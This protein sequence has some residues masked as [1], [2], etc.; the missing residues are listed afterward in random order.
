[1]ITK[2]FLGRALKDGAGTN[3][4]R[5]KRRLPWEVKKLKAG[6]GWGRGPYWDLRRENKLYLGA[7]TKAMFRIQGKT[8][9][10]KVQ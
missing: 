3:R 9:S 10:K 8:A 6:V 7:I 5:K 2:G 4:R 1:M